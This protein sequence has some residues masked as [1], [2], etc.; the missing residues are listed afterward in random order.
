M[1]FTSVDIFLYIF[2][3]LLFPFFIY[4]FFLTQYSATYGPPT[5]PFIGCLISF[6][7]NRRRLLDWYTELLTESPS[8]TIVVNRLGAL[9]TIVTANPE[10][11]EYILKT[12][13]Q[14][15]PKGHQYGELLG[16]LL[17]Q[18][19]F[20]VDGELW[21]TQ[22]KIASHE[23]TT[24]SLREFVVKTLE[25][26][27]ESRLFPLLQSA[28]KEGKIID[29]QEV[30]KRFTYDTIC[31][32]SLGIDPNCLD[33]SVPI[34]PLI[35]AFETAGEISARRS[36][37]PIYLIWKLKRAF[38]LGSEAKLKQS[39]NVVH[40][41]ITNI[42]RQ[43]QKSLSTSKTDAQNPNPNPNPNPCTHDLL[44]RFLSAGYDLE[45]TRDM[46]MSFI[47][48]GRDTTA[49]AMTWLFWVISSDNTSVRDS[50]RDELGS[51]SGLGLDQLGF[52]V[53]KREMRYLH[54]CLCEAL[55]LY[56]PVPWDS[57]H[58]A[59]DDV[60]PDGTR[61]RKGERVTFFQYGMGR[62]HKIWG[63]DWAKFN[64]DRWFENNKIDHDQEQ[65]DGDD[66]SSTH[67]V[68]KMVSPYVFPVFQ[69]GPRICLGK[70]MAFIQMKYVVASI[71]SRF[72]FEPVSNEPPVFVPLMT[73]HM[74]G[75]LRVRV[76]EI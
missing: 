14:N 24:N 9:K 5:Y 58:A 50:I 47:M 30:L 42:I 34:P 8:Q 70:D 75:G 32:V 74:A 20:I 68:L 11:V 38:N 33:L 76:K 23:F 44:S 52:E 48:A 67:R 41:L 18:G 7:Q 28:A 16:D 13:F 29:M 66:N 35:A 1:S 61:V 2:V 27:V 45:L 69:A 15:F 36:T 26:E 71:L 43:K 25:D 49:A 37:S 62:M 31:K 63:N 19:I 54:A 12:K 21:S 64:P 51:G 39:I 60:L 6:Y 73:A 3:L 56:P 10:N 22:R 57:K 4:K 55:R 65:R 17:G 40:T 46:V 59:N 53:V 72:D